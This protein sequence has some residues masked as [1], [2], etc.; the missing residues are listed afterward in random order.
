MFSSSVQ[1]RFL[2]DAGFCSMPVSARCRFLLD[3]GFCSMPVQ[4]SW[5]LADPPDAQAD[6][7]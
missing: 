1:Y 2:L 7:R 6:G 5:T 4:T 3:A